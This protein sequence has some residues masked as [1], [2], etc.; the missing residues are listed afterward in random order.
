[1]V[2]NPLITLSTARAFATSGAPRLAQAA[3]GVQAC[4]PQAAAAP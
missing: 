3:G 4:W 2:Q 1:M